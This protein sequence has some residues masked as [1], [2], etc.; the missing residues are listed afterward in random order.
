MIDFTLNNNE[1]VK[2]NYKFILE[3]CKKYNTNEDCRQEIFLY[4]LERDLS[5]VKNIKSWLRR[6]V[7]LMTFSPRS[8]YNNKYRWDF[9][10]YDESEMND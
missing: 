10:D 8:I 3:L 1:I 6:L 4:I 9:E 2:E 7:Y 5:G